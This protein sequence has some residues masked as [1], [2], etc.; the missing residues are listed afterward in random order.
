MVYLRHSV[1]TYINR[2]YRRDPW[3]PTS[4][5]LRDSRAF[6]YGARADAFCSGHRRM[7]V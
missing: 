6:F 1:L 4:N 7:G 2:A 5:P 3:H